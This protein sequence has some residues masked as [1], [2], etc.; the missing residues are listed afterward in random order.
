[1][2]CG[3]AGK[4][5]ALGDVGTKKDGYGI[6]GMDV[7]RS[8]VVSVPVDSGHIASFDRRKCKEPLNGPG[9]E[10]GE[11]CPEGW[12]FYSLPGPSQQGDS[13][14]AENPYY[15]EVIE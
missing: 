3:I 6:R 13:G 12:R 4:C 5:P 15:E 9:A 1:M 8:G 2:V 11:K 14:V 7:D 10:L